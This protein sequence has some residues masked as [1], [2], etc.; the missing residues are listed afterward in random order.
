MLVKCRK[1]EN[2][3]NQKKVGNWKNLK[4]LKGNRKKQY[5]G[6]SKKSD[7]VGNQIKKEIRKKQ[8]NG[9]SRKS[10]KKYKNKKKQEIKK[11]KIF[12]KKIEN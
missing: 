11:Q 3:G 6:K 10:N 8:E 2:V 12:L 4:I 7:K 9:K 5:I 1:S